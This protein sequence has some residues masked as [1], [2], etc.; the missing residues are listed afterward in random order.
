MD[1]PEP[2]LDQPSS[3][4]KMDPKYQEPNIVVKVGTLAGGIILYGAMAA[5]IL[6]GCIIDPAG[7][8]F[9]GA[10]NDEPVPQVKE[11]QKEFRN[12]KK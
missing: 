12:E 4:P 2:T 7:K 1:T 3:M 5:A 8:V 10:W 9:R 11:K 6:K